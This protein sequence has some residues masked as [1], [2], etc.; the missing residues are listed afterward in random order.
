MFQTSNSSKQL[1]TRNANS[2][3]ASTWI[4]TWVEYGLFTPPSYQEIFINAKQ[5]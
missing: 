5:M 2:R 3:T 4:F 1:E